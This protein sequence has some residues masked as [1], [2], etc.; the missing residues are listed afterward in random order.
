M[1]N[2]WILEGTEYCKQCDRKNNWN[3]MRKLAQVIQ[4]REMCVC[5]CLCLE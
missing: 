1:K 5:F 4:Q 2:E 3:K